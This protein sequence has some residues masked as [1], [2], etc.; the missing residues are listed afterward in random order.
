MVLQ[1]IFGLNKHIEGMAD[2][3]ARHGYLAIAPALFDRQERRVELAHDSEGTARGMALASNAS[4]AGLRADLTASGDVV[5][6]TGAVGLV[7]YC[8]GG[9]IVF[10]ASGHANVACGVVYYGGGIPALLDEVTPRCPLQFHFG[11]QDPH[12]PLSDVDR[13]R[14][15]CPTAE[16]HL[17]PAGHGF[18]C[19]DR[20]S[21]DASAAHLAFQRSL[22]FLEKHVG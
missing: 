5:L 1:E 18:N 2:R 3:Y 7:G 9:R 6:H 19:P 11:T 13:I 16:I 21:Y 22:E 8:W 4:T 10:Q 20:S 15:A 14:A 12:I 17:Y